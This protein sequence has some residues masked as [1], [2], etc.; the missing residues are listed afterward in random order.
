MYVKKSCL[1]FSIVFLFSCRE[2]EIIVKHCVPLGYEGPIFEIVKKGFS[3]ERANNDTVF[4]DYDSNGFAY[5]A[6][7]KSEPNIKKK[8]V[9]IYVKDGKD[10]VI[11]PQ[12]K[13]L[14]WGAINLEGYDY[15]VNVVWNNLYD[16][17]FNIKADSVI[18]KLK[19][20]AH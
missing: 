7:K 18:K 19:N 9:F 13:L 12:N 20:D 17:S 1:L 2:K 14:T 8:E 3:I 11:I 10:M 5:N 6:P 4:I 16:N 15:R